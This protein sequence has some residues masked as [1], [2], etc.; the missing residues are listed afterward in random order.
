MKKTGL[1][2]ITL[3]LIAFIFG[4]CLTVEQ[5]EYIIEMTGK[6]AGKLT[7]KYTNIMSSSTSDTIDS[8]P[9][10]FDE[11]IG[12]YMNGDEM[13]KT[14][15]NCTNIKKRLFIENDKLNG[16]VTMDFK[17]IKDIK[18]FRYQGKGPFMMSTSAFSSMETYVSSNG[19]YGEEVMPVV[20]W[21]KKTKKMTLTCTVTT[22][23]DKTTSLARLYK[24]YEK[25]NK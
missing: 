23:D 19:T 5:K 13:E 9:D 8:S 3:A 6:N 12:K 18:L 20:F 11:L 14:F 21:D 22:P 17:D 10:D 25:N 16:E 4:G 15:P 2:F 1:L 7:I 24:K